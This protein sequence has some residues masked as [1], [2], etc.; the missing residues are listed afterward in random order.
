MKYRGVKHQNMKIALAHDDLCQ[1]GG[2]ERV[3]LE[4]SSL[5]DRPPLYIALYSDTIISKFHD[6]IGKLRT[7]F[8]NNYKIIKKHPKS[9]FFL[10]PL[11][12]ESFNFDEYDVVISSSTRFA[13]GIIT[14]PDTLHI[15]YMHSPSRYIW[16]YNEYMKMYNIKGIKK[17]ILP[18]MVSYLR[19]WD[20]QASARPDFFIAN[21][22]YTRGRIKKFYNKDSVVINPPVN[23]ERFINGKVE[24]HG[25]YLYIGRVVPWKRV[26]I[27]IDA[28]KTLKYPLHIV[29]NGESSYINTLKDNATDNIT[30]YEN[31]DDKKVEDQLLRCRGLLFPSKEDFGIVPVEALACGK[32]VIAY[33]EGGVKDTIEDQKTGVFFKKQDKEDVVDAVIRFEKLK[34]DIDYLRKVSLGFKRE[35]FRDKIEEFVK[36]KWEQR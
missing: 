21:S 20:M 13:H 27:L 23:V 11:A 28:F 4:L 8:L 31:L 34:F 24:D 26:D 9:F 35:I 10:N 33:E 5:Y 22:E 30:F 16:D 15:C 36:S 19:I 17:K 29:G 1:F 18:L 7:S 14:G 12:F 32:G 6:Q 25:Y 3:V 2:A